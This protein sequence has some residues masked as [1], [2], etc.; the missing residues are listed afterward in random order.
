LHHSSNVGAGDGMIYLGVE[1]VE[2]GVGP[3]GGTPDLAVYDLVGLLHD[4][5]QWN[6]T[7]REGLAA[8]LAAHVALVTHGGGVSRPDGDYVEHGRFV[9]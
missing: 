3:I 5:A 6:A 4:H 1:V 2:L 8:R 9:I 7:A